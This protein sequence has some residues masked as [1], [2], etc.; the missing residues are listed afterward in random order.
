MNKLPKIKRR[1]PKIEKIIDNKNEIKNEVKNEIKNKNKKT[2]INYKN[3]KKAL[4]LILGLF[5]AFLHIILAAIVCYITYFSNNIKLLLIVTII[6]LYVLIQ[7]I[8]IG[9]CIL[10]PI[11]NY[12]LKD[13]IKFDNIKK[14]ILLNFI[15]YF[16]KKY[17]RFGLNTLIIIV[18]IISIIILTI[19][20]IKIYLLRDDLYP[21]ITSVV[22][23]IQRLYI[24]CN[25][26]PTSLSRCIINFS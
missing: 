22:E 25:G 15:C 16:L 19:Q 3:L 1:H 17:F 10:S 9:F 23:T 18:Y 2:I 13:F 11:E 8:I 5:F 24:R 12:L 14:S 21:L 4:F 26:C 7:W 20:F 6:T